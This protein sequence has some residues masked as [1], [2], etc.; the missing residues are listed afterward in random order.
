MG[1]LC[2]VRTRRMPSAVS[3]TTREANRYEQVTRGGNFEQGSLHAV[4]DL[5]SGPRRRLP[6]EGH[7]LHGDNRA[8]HRAARRWMPGRQCPSEGITHA[9]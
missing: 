8:S 3:M 5:L 6:C 2:L 4:V 1:R 7:E 9:A